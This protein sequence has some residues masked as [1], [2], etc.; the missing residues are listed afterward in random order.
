MISRVTVEN[1]RKR[2]E[3]HISSNSAMRITGVIV[4]SPALSDGTVE[5]CIGMK[6]FYMSEDQAEAA[7]AL[8]VI[9][10]SAPRMTNT[11]ISEARQQFT[12]EEFAQYCAHCLAPK[13][14]MGTSAYVGR[15]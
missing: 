5:V 4:R 10:D 14:Q 7:R 12:D 6:R 13:D 9:P 15:R 3:Q 11:P 8:G 1:L 2:V